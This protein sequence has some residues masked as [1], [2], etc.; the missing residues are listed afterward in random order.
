M[1]L[2]LLTVLAVGAVASAS[3][4]AAA[5]VFTCG[6]PGGSTW[7]FETQAK[8]YA[9][10]P[11]ISNGTW[12]RLDLPS[13]TLVTGLGGLS[14]LATKLSSVTLSI[15]CLDVHIDGRLDSAALLLGLILKSLDCAVT[16]QF[17]KKCEVA[18]TLTT[19]S[20]NGTPTS[21]GRQEITFQS[22]SS[23]FIELTITTK[24]GQICSIANTYPITGTQ[25]CALDKTEKEGEEGKT[26]HELICTTA[27]SKLELGT[28]P[29]TYEGNATVEMGGKTWAMIG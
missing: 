21:A 28:E 20:L 5:L 8:C 4:S 2:S 23:T 26:T 18:P 10:T 11:V 1:L 9:G 15:Q 22:E 19:N 13:G 25:K 3:A 24:A 16:G 27:G 14:V 12:E 7:K 29:A 6:Q 17:G